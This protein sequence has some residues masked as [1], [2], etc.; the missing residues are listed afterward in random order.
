MNALKKVTN[1]AVRGYKSRKHGMIWA[2]ISVLTCVL[3]ALAGGSA[4]HGREGSRGQS[5]LEVTNAIA[6]TRL[7]DNL[8]FNGEPA[9]G[10][11]ASF[12][13]DGKRFVVVLRRGHLEK[14]TNEFSL[15][16]F[17]TA[18][19]R[20]E[21]RPEPALT[22]SSSSNRD[23]IHDL[24]WLDDNQTVAFV[25]ERQNEQAQVYTFNFATGQLRNQTEHP[26]S[27]TSFD[28]SR[29]GRVILYAAELPTRRQDSSRAVEWEGLAITG[30]SLPSLLAG[31]CFES[32]EQGLFVKRDGVRSIELKMDD[33]ILD[34]SPLKISPDGKHALVG[35]YARNYPQSWNGY[36][37]QYIRKLLTSES[38]RAEASYLRLKRYWLMDLS[39]GSASPL[40]DTP[41]T[42]FS[43][44]V[45]SADGASIFLRAM[46]VP[47]R[48][49]AGGT[50]AETEI[51]D[52]QVDVTSRAW[53]VI[54]K[55]QWPR[56]N[57]RKAEIEVSLDEDINAPPKIYVSGRDVPGRKLL[58]DLNPDFADLPLGRVETMEWKVFGVTLLGGLYLPANYR[59]G[60]RYPLVVQTHGYDSTR[61][62]MDGR[63]EWSSGFAA[64][65]LASKGFLVLQTYAFKDA[66]GYQE[67]GSNRHLGLT[68][69]QAFKRFNALAYEK[70]VDH[71]NALGLIDSHRVGISGF[72][73]TVCFVAYALTHSKTKFAAAI[74]TDGIDCGYFGY[75]SYPSGSWDLERLNGG[76]S[77]FLRGGVRDWS[78]EAPSFNLDKVTAPVRL[79]ALGR[80]SILQQ[81][82]WYVG[83]TGLGKAVDFVEIPDAAHLLQK[84]SDRRI[85]EEGIVDWFCFW[86][87]GEEDA[88]PRKRAQFERWRRLRNESKSSVH[89]Y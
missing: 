77:P 15:Y 68:E 43:P 60:V 46:R 87:K 7:A 37:G 30:Q 16:V 75:V 5:Q 56:S 22:M 84:P 69:E 88:D 33:T 55:D 45:W 6:M 26:T 41:M 28:I 65:A 49:A 66:K 76:R 10:R 74:L 8:Y 29:D 71:L 39:S 61:F 40:I 62:A 20:G 50:T 32:I 1:E 86:L 19:A 67:V 83:L 78:I 35:A 24:E 3:P 44:A 81:W 9:A 25:G 34:R 51:Y 11:V 80:E 2:Q 82:E 52:I 85:A 47:L 79:V 42:T 59:A 18:D 12:S 48:S 27:V 70:A 4:A 36:Q 64:R 13:P 14:N 73:R 89:S 21:R 57:Q 54:D 17:D 38:R 23:A 63:N 72:S 53:R 58:L 31:D